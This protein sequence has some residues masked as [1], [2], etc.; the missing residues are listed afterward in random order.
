MNVAA[1]RPTSRTPDPRQV[2]LPPHAP[3][4]GRLRRLLGP[5]YVTGVFWYRIHG[6]GVVFFPSWF[7]GACVVSFSAF[8]FVTLRNIRRAIAANLV[9]VLG[10]CGWWR[11]QGRILK[12][13]Y[14]FGWCLTERYE[15]L[16]TERRFD[17]RA[18]GAEHWERL[19]RSGRGCILVT[20]HLGSWEIGSVLPAEESRTVHV[21]R[22]AET[23]PRAQRYIAELVSSRAGGRYMTHFADDPRLGVVLLDALRRGE[24]VA[25]QG[26]RPRTRGRVL[27]LSLF[28]R[29]FPLPGGP[30]ALARAAGVPLVP[31]FVLR[32]GRRRY[33]CE[34]RPPIEPGQTAD[35]QGDVEAASRRF[36]AELEGAIA[37]E[38]HQWF[39]FRS[40]WPQVEDRGP[41]LNQT[42]PQ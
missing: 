24:I 13:M 22:E 19:G 12:T 6:N 9:P 30:A 29:P 3:Q 39:C 42:A 33:R 26:D 1:A 16:R 7:L 34:I 41:V 20:G 40:L 5:F 32:E 15:R 38:P 21:V 27:E 23:D 28:G 10:P 2:P 25:L 18:D 17:V 31:V 37:R 36:A 11:R 14:Y 8:F 4:T 35:R